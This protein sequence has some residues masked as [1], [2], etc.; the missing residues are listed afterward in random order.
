MEGHAGGPVGTL[1]LLLAAAV[2]LSGLLAPARAM[3]PAQA[4]VAAPA[5]WE[6]WRRLP[7][8][9]DIA[10]PRAD[11]T[12]VAAAGGKLHTVARDGT[13][14]PFSDYAT[15]PSPESYIAMVP[16]DRPRAAAP[17]ADECRFDAGDVFALELSSLGVM[18]VSAAGTASLFAHIDGADS[19]NGIAFDATGRFGSRLLVVARRGDR[20]RVVAVDCKGAATVV[21]DNAPLMEGGVAVAPEEFGVHAGELIGAD[22]ISGDVVFVRADGQ[23]GVLVKSGLPAGQDVGVESVGFLPAEFTNRR[24]VVLMADR[25]VAGAPSNGTDSIWRLS[26]EAIRRSGLG[27][28]DLLVASEQAGRTVGV[29]CRATCRLFPVGQAADAA[30]VEGHITA[31]LDPPVNA[32]YKRTGTITFLAVVAFVIVAG[33]IVVLFYRRKSPYHGNQRRA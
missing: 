30:H 9:V 2:A 11:G 33:T 8:V 7:G 26:D 12:L 17:A 6:Q 23:S 28:G 31:L 4:Q 25:A 20:T 15:D 22:E 32:G 27:G 19:L 10:G 1:K 24:G 13:I 29:R 14:S 21:A 3:A 18:R 16:A 5:P